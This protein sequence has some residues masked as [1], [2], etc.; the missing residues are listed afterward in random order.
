MSTIDGRE[1]YINLAD[2][3]SDESAT[4]LDFDETCRATALA[5][6]EDYGLPWPPIGDV[7]TAIDLIER[8]EKKRTLTSASHANQKIF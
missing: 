4:L 3:L 7:D 2:E 6:A 1:A 5:F 8:A